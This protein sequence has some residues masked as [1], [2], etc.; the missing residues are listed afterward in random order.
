[1]TCSSTACV[2]GPEGPC[3]SIPANSPAGPVW[4]EAP[5]PPR[6]TA[7][8]FTFPAE[9]TRAPPPPFMCVGPRAVNKR[10]GPSSTGTTV[11]GSL[12]PGTPF[13]VIADEF[14]WIN[15]AE[16]KGGPSF[17]IG[18]SFAVPCSKRC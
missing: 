13:R 9:E 12:R 4:N 5:P 6:P 17:Y 1:M 10:S 8:P 3:K 11:L 2:K 15:A 18:S 14:G 7:V 16:C